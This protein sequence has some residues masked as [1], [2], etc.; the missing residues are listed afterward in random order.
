MVL[1]LVDYMVSYREQSKWITYP[2]IFISKNECVCLMGESGCGKTTL[3][4]SMFDPYFNGAVRYKTAQI[5]GKGIKE[6]GEE[7]FKHI[8]YMPQYSQSG[9]NP[10][11]SLKEHIDMI[12]ASTEIVDYETIHKYYK[13]LGLNEDIEKMYPYELSGGMK[14]R[15][16]MLMGF[17]KK[18]KFFVLD[19]PSS[20]IDYI[21]LEKMIDFLNHR[22][23]EGCAMLVMSHHKGFS[24][25][26]A[27][28]VIEISGDDHE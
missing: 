8:S 4:N 27:D 15:F 26:I 6:W 24:Q 17:I 20:A 19:E 11:L 18:P 1:S 12:E 14:Q 2:D 16:V 23:S 25:M 5:A 22:R 7:L 10:M 21:T 13:Q 28:K 3:L 9:L